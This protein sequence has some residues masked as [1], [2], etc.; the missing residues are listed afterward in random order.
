M[1]RLRV[2]RHFGKNERPENYDLIKTNVYDNQVLL[3][4]MPSYLDNLL[5]LPPKL[6]E[7][8]LKGN[9]DVFDGQFFEQFDRNIHV[10][11][12]WV[13]MDGVKKRIVCL[14][15]GY[16][17]PSAVYRIALMNDGR[18]IIYRELYVTGHTLKQLALRIKAMSPV[19][20]QINL[21]VYDPALNKKGEDSGV[22]LSDYLR[23]TGFRIKPGNN[24]RVP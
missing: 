8:Y 3:K 12:P 11:S 14:D 22:V 21:L 15:Y 5:A 17:N 13:P 20:E 24:A 2:D 7:A 18:V 19:G 4:V 1:K 6:R 16:T 10:I 23:L 9:W